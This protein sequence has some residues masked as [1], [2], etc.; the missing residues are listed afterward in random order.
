MRYPHEGDPELLDLV[1]R[2]ITVD[3][4]YRRLGGRL[5][6]LDGPERA[7]FAQELADAAGEITPRELGVLLEAG[8]RERRTAAWLIAVAGRTE[9]RDRLGEL[10]LDSEVCYAG[11]GYCVALATFG[12]VADAD[13]LCAYLDRYLRRPDLRY[14][15]EFAIGALLHLDSR[16]TTDRVSRFAGE[17]GLWEQW[18]GEPTI[19]PHSYGR[20]VGQFC[21]FAS[22]SAARTKQGHA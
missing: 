2:Y 16:S 19:D 8:W 20:I 12:T 13:L 4:R 18:I 1:R 15:Q 10:L 5:L 17:G 11:Q 21:A 3:R 14:D 7:Q 22:E 9:F 6:R